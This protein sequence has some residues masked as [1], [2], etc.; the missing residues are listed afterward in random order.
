MTEAI[1]VLVVGLLWTLI[2]SEFEGQN[3][4]CVPS[5]VGPSIAGLEAGQ[6]LLHFL[7]TLALPAYVETIDKQHV[8]CY[9]MI[10]LICTGSAYFVYKSLLPFPAL[11]MYVLC[12]MALKS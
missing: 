5:R 8:L 2:A 6:S 3:W 1:T 9:W 11:F 7:L 12:A 4:F 10:T